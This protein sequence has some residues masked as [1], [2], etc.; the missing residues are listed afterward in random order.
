MKNIREIL[1]SNLKKL[2]LQ[3]GW[4]QIFVA[5]NLQITE[6]FLSQIESGKKGISLDLIESFSNF[7]N[8]P[9]A[10]LFID[11]ENSDDSSL[12]NLELKSLEE[13]LKEKISKCISE[14]IE[15]LKNN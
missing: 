14:S 15:L 11:T 13:N 6:S 7:F 9:I 2:R 8:V 12:R 10:S 4:T 3:K 1:G 5:E